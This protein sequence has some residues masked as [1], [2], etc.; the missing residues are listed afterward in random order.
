MARNVN[1]G[2]DRLTYRQVLT[3]PGLQALALRFKTTQT[4]TNAEL[5]GYHNSSTRNGFGIILNNTAGK[6][7]VVA[8]DATT[9]R[10]N[11]TGTTTVNDGN[12]HSLVLSANAVNGGTNTLYIDGVQDATANSSAQWGA[13]ANSDLTLGDSLDTFWPSPVADA[14]DFAFWN[15]AILTVEEAAAYHKG[16][17]A[18]H[19]KLDN[20]ETYAPLVRSANCLMG[21]TTTVTGTTVVDHPRVIGSMV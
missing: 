13:A 12:W 9:Q 14:A 6:V 19:F 4:T 5:I 3:A 18:R 16:F 10:L 2:T 21:K 1:G 11:M 15:G 17:S 20:L 7:T 8:Y